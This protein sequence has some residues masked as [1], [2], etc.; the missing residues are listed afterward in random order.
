MS[1]RISVYVS[2]GTSNIES[3]FRTMLLVYEFVVVCTGCGGDFRTVDCLLMMSYMGRVCARTTYKRRQVHMGHP[4][5]E[6]QYSS[7]LL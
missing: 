2:R 5:L 6:K 3:L 4:G 7:F 1:P